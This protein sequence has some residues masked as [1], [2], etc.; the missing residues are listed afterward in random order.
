MARVN[1]EFRK[2]E[3]NCVPVPGNWE[4]PRKPIARSEIKLSYFCQNHVITD[5]LLRRYTNIKR[6]KEKM[7]DSNF[8]E[9]QNRGR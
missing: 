9:L 8:T 6:L 2:G 7:Y 4:P 1:L 3:P 5:F